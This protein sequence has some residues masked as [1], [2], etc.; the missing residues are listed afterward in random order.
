MVSGGVNQCIKYTLFVFNF[1]FVAVGIFLTTVGIIPLNNG[2]RYLT[3]IDT[4]SFTAPPKLFIAIGV[5][6][7]VIAFLGCC[8]AYAE[9][10]SMIMAYSVLVGL[11]LILQLGVGIAALTLQDDLENVA[12]EGLMKTLKQF[13]NKSVPDVK[14]IRSS[15]NLLQ[16]ELKCCGVSGYK[17]WKGTF[18]PE[19]PATDNDTLVPSS[20][21]VEGIV[22]HCAEAITDKNIDTMDVTGLVFTEGCLHK[23]IE[24]LAIDKF[25]MIGIVLAVVEFLGV[26]CACL[27]ARSIRFS[28]ET[29]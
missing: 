22:D 21:C 10:H 20:C 11:I 18:I 15:W 14:D 13:H 26:I 29:V 23:A 27:L 19:S 3:L 5:I 1:I 8:G 9:N 28:Y 17:D 7:F 2:F 25:G 24:H 6:M 16:S 12:Q 4:G